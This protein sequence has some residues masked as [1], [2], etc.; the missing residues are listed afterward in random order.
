MASLKQRC[1][2]SRTRFVSRATVLCSR[3]TRAAAAA[4]GSSAKQRRRTPRSVGKSNAHVRSPP[5][6]TAPPHWFLG[7]L[8][9]CRSALLQHRPCTA[10]PTNQP[11]TPH[12]QGVRDGW[13]RRGR[14]TLA[15]KVWG[16]CGGAATIP[17]PHRA[18]PTGKSGCIQACPSRRISARAACG[19]PMGMATAKR[20]VVA[21]ALG[22]F[23]D[24]KLG[25][26]AVRGI[27][28]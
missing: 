3:T 21:W 23:V 5:P 25:L 7:Y 15:W 27:S 22:A 9:Q 26:V 14:S 17:P 16:Q 18:W 24:T 8:R 11:P 20:P 10:Q 4:L 12:G 19:P 6:P 2:L 13:R 28:V 1:R